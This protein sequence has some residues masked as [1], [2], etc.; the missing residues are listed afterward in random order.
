MTK[1]QY[2]IFYFMV[3]IIVMPILLLPSAAFP[4]TA[5][6]P[7]LVVS[8]PQNDLADMAKAGGGF[9][10]KILYYL[11]TA[12]FLAFRA[13]FSAVWY[14]FK[15]SI[16]LTTEYSPEVIAHLKTGRR[17]YRI[18][19]G[20]HFES[21]TRPIRIYAAPMIGLYH[22]RAAEKIEGEIAWKSE[23]AST[24][25]FGWT[26]GAGFLVDLTHWQEHNLELGLDIG[27]HY[28]AVQDLCGPWPFLDSE[29]RDADEIAVNVGA[30]VT[31]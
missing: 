6:G 7:A 14:G 12:P 17:S 25:K 3:V 27:A 23:C 30:L 1:V 15:E 31:F 13:D 20:P 16:P 26:L 19:L 18:T 4:K 10:A 2:K 28:H 9:G 21:P 11:P 24:M 5:L 29:N 22:H 8:I